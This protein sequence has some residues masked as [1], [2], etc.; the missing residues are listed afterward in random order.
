MVSNLMTAG[1]G[2][3]IRHCIP[4]DGGGIRHCIGKYRLGSVRR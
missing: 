4:G 1:D 2:G 3:G